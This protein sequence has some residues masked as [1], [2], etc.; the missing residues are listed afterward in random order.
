VSSPDV[1][2]G[3]GKFVE[4]RKEIACEFREVEDEEKLWKICDTLTEK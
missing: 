1:E 2:G 4:Q 3:S